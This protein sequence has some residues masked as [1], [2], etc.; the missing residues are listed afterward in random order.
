[1][2]NNLKLQKLK[3]LNQKRAQILL[4]LLNQ[5]Q[6]KMKQKLTKMKQKLLKIKNK[7]L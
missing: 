5:K 6:L 3:K 7:K 4:A 1:M 2:I